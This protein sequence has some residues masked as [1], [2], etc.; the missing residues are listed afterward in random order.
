M[1]SA[2]GTAATVPVESAV[3]KEDGGPRMWWT[4]AITSIALFMV[5]LDNLIVTNAL[6]TIQRDFNATVQGPRV[7]RQRVHAHLRSASAHGCGTRRPLRPAAHVRGRA[8]DP[9]YRV[10]R[11]RKCRPTSS[12]SMRHARFRVSAARS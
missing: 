1:T 10:G 8:G 6:P 4:L 5:T 7:D 12:R 9:Y 2:P 3:S 11:G